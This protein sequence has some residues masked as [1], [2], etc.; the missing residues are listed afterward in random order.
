MNELNFT[1][2]DSIAGYVTRYD[3]KSDAFDMK[4]SDGREFRIALTSTTYA[5]LLRNIGEAYQDVSAKMRA[6]LVPGRYLFAYGI[7]YPDGRQ[8]RFEVK[9]IVFVGRRENE[10]RFEE[11][12]WWITQ[13]RQ[14]ADFYLRAQFPD[15]EID[16]ARY[17]THLSVEGLKLASNR[18]EADTISRL[19]YGLASAYL[20]TGDDRYWEAAT[21]GTEYLRNHFR[22]TDKT[23]GV[24]YWYHAIDF[25]ANGSIRKILASEF[26]EDYYAIPCY[27]QIYAL[28]GPTQTYRITGDAR[29]LSDIHSTLALFERFFKDKSERGGYYTHL[30]PITLSPHSDSLG[31]NRSRKNWNSVGD[32]APA[33]LI[34]LYLAT[35]APE[36]LAFLEETFDTIAEHFPDYDN[37][38]FVMEKFNDDWSHDYTTVQRNRAII[39]HNLKIAWNLMRMASVKPK[40]EYL[41]LAKRIAATMPDLGMDKQRGG[42]YDMVERV[43]QKG[44]DFHRFVWHDRKAW[45]QQE[46]GILAYLLLHGATDDPEYLRLARE[47]AAFYSAAFLDAEVGG[48]YFSVLAS[49][50]PFMVGGERSKGN[51]SEGLYHQGELCYLGA[52]Y[53]NL[54]ITRQ[55]MD[56]YFRPMA[57]GFPDN[58]LRVSPDF[59]PPGSVRI[60]EVWIDGRKHADF[61]AEAMTVNLPPHADD[62]KVRVRLV[63]ASVAFSA[64]PLDVK[65]GVFRFALTGDLESAG[66]RHLQEQIERVGGGNGAGVI[67]V[68]DDLRSISNE[69]LRLLAFSKQRY[70]QNFSIAVVGAK[71]DVREA[72]ACSGLDE[73]IE[74]LD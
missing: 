28:A 39:G 65:D 68:V 15:G 7:F 5:E 21:K 43:K 16:F 20:L 24:R 13:I 59:L 50:L 10:Y 12:D 17:R 9:H 73:E 69:A 38:P 58:V 52:V 61:D 71:G 27:E 54:L 18:Q 55:P 36:A 8:T 25:T 42:W 6:M 51:H 45:W 35:G 46:Q 53:T 23:A 33:Y 62:L 26:G 47:S 30:D 32:H 48:V 74:F 1:F 3:T 31:A 11:Q 60:N 40:P 44:H 57:G 14:C 2:S 49:G 63:P 70:G 34:N 19:V 66:V 29:I 41:A 72:F 37:S 22:F 4:T 67:L 64:A 56:F